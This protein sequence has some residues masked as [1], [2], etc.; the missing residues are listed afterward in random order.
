MKTILGLIG[1][2]ERDAVIL[3]TAFAAA[4]PLSAHLDFLHV[5]V[6][7]GIAARYDKTVQFAV[8][9]AIGD[10]LN[11]LTSKAH[12][13]SN[14]AKEHFSE[15]CARS[16][17]EIRDDAPTNGKNVTA[18]FREENDTTIER[19]IFHVRHSDLVVLG[20]ARQTQGLSPETLEHLIRNCGTSCPCGGYWRAAIAHRHRHGVLAKIQSC[21]A[22]G[23]GRHAHSDECETRHI[24]KHH[25]AQQGRC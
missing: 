13:F 14:V 19:L 16:K 22:C 10:A 23:R 8:G 15:F 7:A 2:G 18:R 21:G 25:N 1:G 11:D 3:Q 12:K 17:I 24:C 20:R 5:R 4:A 6:S 9:S